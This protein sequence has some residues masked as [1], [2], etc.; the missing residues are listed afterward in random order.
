MIQIFDNKII[1]R[2]KVMVEYYKT[3]QMISRVNFNNI[4][5]AN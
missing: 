5:K 1:A 2:K 3:E 4:K